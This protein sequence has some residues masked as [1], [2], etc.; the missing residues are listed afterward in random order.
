VSNGC[1]LAKTPIGCFHKLSNGKFLSGKSRRNSLASQY[2]SPQSANIKMADDLA[3]ITHYLKAYEAGYM[4]N[5]WI[6]MVF[7]SAQN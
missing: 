5:T 1:F 6:Y 3:F 4:F 2:R 7:F